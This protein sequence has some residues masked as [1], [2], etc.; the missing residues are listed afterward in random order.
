MLRTGTKYSAVLLLY[1]SSMILVLE[2]SKYSSTPY[3]LYILL[4]TVVYD[5]HLLERWIQQQ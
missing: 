3:Y 1:R 5:N 4:S 2:G